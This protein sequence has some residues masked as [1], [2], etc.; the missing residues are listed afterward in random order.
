MDASRLLTVGELSRQLGVPV[1]R[2]R[3]LLLAR[4]MRPTAR[5]GQAWIYGREVLERL[6]LEMPSG[7]GVR[8]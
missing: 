3:Y 4:G 6:R 8:P 2:V 5:A 7:A 1:H